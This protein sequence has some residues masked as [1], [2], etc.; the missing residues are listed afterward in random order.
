ME[1]GRRNGRASC[2]QDGDALSELPNLESYGL[3]CVTLD[4][5]LWPGADSLDC[6][7]MLTS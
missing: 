7:S 3:V 5:Y 2:F 4:R 6:T 1:H